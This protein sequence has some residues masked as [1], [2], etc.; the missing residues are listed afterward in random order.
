[1]M[2]IGGNGCPLWLAF[3]LAAAGLAQAQ[4]ATETVIFNFAEFPQGANPYGTL[5]RNAGGTLYGTA[6]D[7]GVFNLGAVFELAA[8]GYK[9][10]YSFKGSADG[11]NPYAGVVQDSAANLYGT[12]YLGGPANAGVV[13]KV[14]PSG[15]ETVLY[16]FTGGADGGN[17]YAGVILDTAGNVYGT[18]LKG[19]SGNCSGGCG[20]VYKITPAGQQNV[21]YSFTGA[22]DGASPYGGVIA[23]EAGNLYGTTS[24]GGDSITPEGVVYK[25]STAGRETGLHTF[26]KTN[27]PGSGPTSGLVRDAAGNLY[28]NG[29][30][31]VYEI[32]VSGQYKALAYLNDCL[33]IGAGDAWS[34]V[35]VDGAGNVYGTTGV[36]PS[37]CGGVGDAPYG[38]VYKVEPSGTVKVLYRFPGASRPNNTSTAPIVASNPGVVLDSAGNIYGATPYGGVSGMVYLI[39]ASGGEKVL[40]N[41]VGA[42]G[43]S[44]PAAVSLSS[45]G[46]FYGAT[47]AGGAA[48][49]GTV[50]EIDSKGRETM[51]YSFTGGDDGGFPVGKVVKDSAGNLYG[52]TAQGGA[53]NEGVVYKISAGG[54]YSVLHSFTGGADGGSPNGVVMDAG[55]NL[56]GTTF[57][58]G[59]GSLTGVQEGVIFKLDPAGNETVLYSFTGLS[60]GVHPRRSRLSTWPGISMARRRQAAPGL[61]WC[62]RWVLVGGI[63]CYIPS[64]AQ[65]PTGGILRRAWFWTPRGI[66][67]ALRLAGG[68]RRRARLGRAWSSS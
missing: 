12:T 32:T 27:H 9:V 4:T 5:F 67:T 30:T 53:A 14:S 59:A 48:N 1:M 35:A 41:F 57:G 50:Y 51:L 52:V 61:A 8:S 49:A 68:L 13:Y 40:H 38:V 23:D 22:S 33:T 34:G 64:R 28:G 58:G 3:G 21:L 66:F 17:P 6:F 25:V 62:S 63:V 47:E 20:V 10:V 37:S 19:G 31:F 11:A 54:Q 44:G 29:P 43:G 7:G 56:Y 46:G 65:A 36:A 60:D 24:A 45:G 15:E 16:A 42:L 2:R 26:G 18:T 39:G 55:G